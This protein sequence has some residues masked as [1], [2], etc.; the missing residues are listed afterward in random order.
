MKQQGGVTRAFD[1]WKAT[2]RDIRA[3]LAL[4]E[5]WVEPAYQSMWEEAETEFAAGFDPDRQDVDGHVD[6]FHDKVEGLWPADYLCKL[7]SD[8]LRDAVTAFEVYME[9]CLNEV[10]A[11]WSSATRAQS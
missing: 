2:D 11:R 9:K 6:L 3:Y 5:R 4:N 1:L 8:N 7:R 10:L